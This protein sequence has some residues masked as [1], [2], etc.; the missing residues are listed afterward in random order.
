MTLVKKY[1]YT[2]V[3]AFIFAGAVMAL[4]RTS[5]IDL[6]IARQFLTVLPVFFFS[7]GVCF[8]LISI[9]HFIQYPLKETRILYYIIYAFFLG[10]IL[11]EY[12][13]AKQSDYDFNVFQIIA[14]ASGLYAVMVLHDRFTKTTQETGGK[15]S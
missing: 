13:A 9:V 7:I 12:F 3:A 15:E 5:L 10:I 8:L 1:I 14:S 11:Y 6:N 2:C 4:R